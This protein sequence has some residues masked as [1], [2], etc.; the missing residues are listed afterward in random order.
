MALALVGLGC[1]AGTPHLCSTL[2][3][4]LIPL[5]SSTPPL[6]ALHQH[7]TLLDG[8]IPV[9]IHGSS[10]FL[11][12]YFIFTRVVSQGGEALCFWGVGYSSC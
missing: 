9:S 12:N 1:T 10:I 7:Q 4:V 8:Q 3:P 11:K 6:C 5:P 2:H